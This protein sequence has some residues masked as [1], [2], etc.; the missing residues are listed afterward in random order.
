MCS[1][2]ALA[3]WPS[4]VESLRHATR[5]PEVTAQLIGSKTQ[6]KCSGYM[7]HSISWNHTKKPGKR[8]GQVHMGGM[9]EMEGPFLNLGVLN[10]HITWDCNGCHQCVAKWKLHDIKYLCIARKSCISSPSCIF[11]ILW[12]FSTLTPHEYGNMLKV[13]PFN[14]LSSVVTTYLVLN[15]YYE[16]S[17]CST[18]FLLTSSLSI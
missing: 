6:L 9:N 18:N 13:I 16:F 17:L 7:V 15:M 11:I 4:L 8:E 3:G 12:I 5:V 2:I 10:V 14:F 1:L